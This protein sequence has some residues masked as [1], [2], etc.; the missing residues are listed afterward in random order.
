MNL[1]QHIQLYHRE[2]EKQ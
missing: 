1:K 2:K